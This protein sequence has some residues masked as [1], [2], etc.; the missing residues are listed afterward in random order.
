M[1]AGTAGDVYEEEPRTY[2][3]GGGT[4]AARWLTARKVWQ[5]IALLVL[6]AV[7]VIS[8]TISQSIW[9]IIGW[10]ALIAAGA[11]IGRR[12]TSRGDRWTGSQSERLR[13]WLARRFGWDSY[14]PA[15]EAAPFALGR[16][17]FL[18]AAAVEGGPEL[19]V[20]DHVDEDAFTAVIQI[21]GGGE[22][23]L[24]VW[25]SNQRQSRFGR[26]LFEIANDANLP[27]VQLDMITRVTPATARE[28]RA[29]VDQEMRR[30]LPVRVKE[31]MG[32]LSDLAAEISEDFRS[33]AVIRMPLDALRE[34]AQLDLGQDG[35]EALGETAFQVVGE[36]GQLMSA[37]GYEMLLGVPP[38]SMGALIR[39]LYLPS[40]ASDDLTGINRA[41]D[42][43]PAFEP[44]RNGTS[45]LAHDEENGITWHHA[46]GNVPR[47]GWPVDVVTGRLL[48]GLILK[49]PPG[50]YRTVISQFRFL[51]Q[52]EAV[53]RALGAV[54]ADKAKVIGQE[55]RGVVSTGQPEARESA[56]QLVLDDVGTGGHAGVLPMVRVLV[57]A[58]SEQHLS[59][60]RKAI[61]SLATGTVGLTKWQWRD[62]RHAQ[63]MMTCLPLGRGISHT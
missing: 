23:L 55:K 9:V 17:T 30:D 46:I 6:L 18:A 29:H 37:A 16:A 15:R 5:G 51:A 41:V 26:M 48:E 2:F 21:E 54:T 8:T 40:R 61:Q 47:E 38:R 28:Y 43:F 13:S 45:L 39:S 1:S 35:V 19:S 10:A 63:A 34:R 60:A 27:V 7:V 58:P 32:R 57:S 33:Y 20:I 14:D 42:G 31:S 24:E 50:L 59:R 36:V 53:G 56:S 22:G 25:Q 62:G 12:R 44:G 3:V 4:S 49:A 52:P 11:G